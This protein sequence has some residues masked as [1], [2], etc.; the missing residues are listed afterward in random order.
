MHGY[1]TTFNAAKLKLLNET[2][3]YTIL[4]LR[5]HLST[6]AK[7]QQYIYLI[8]YKTLTERQCLVK[9]L[10]LWNKSYN[11]KIKFPDSI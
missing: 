3:L 10:I 2:F 8:L 11:F 6:K 5:E 1:D 9:I 4:S 7:T